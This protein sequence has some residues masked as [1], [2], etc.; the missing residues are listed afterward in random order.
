MLS[1]RDYQWLRVNGAS[2]FDAYIP[3]EAR[4]REDVCWF[5]SLSYVAAGAAWRRVQQWNR[6]SLWLQISNFKA[7]ARAW[8]DLERLNLWTLPGPE[9]EDDWDWY[10][11]ANGMLEVTFDPKRG[12][13]A[14]EDSF[15]NDHIW[16]VAAREDRWLTV[17]L[18]AF[19]DRADIWGR[20][21]EERV[22]VTPEGGIEERVEPDTEFWRQNATLYLVENVPFGTATVLVPRNARDPESYALA[23]AR[24]LVGGVGEPE[25]IDIDD[26]ARQVPGT[27]KPHHRD[28]SVILH[29]HGYY[30][31]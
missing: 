22:T 23:R 11:K 19:A 17:E 28:L 18:A 30:E 8:T 2:R 15:I 10:Y 6:P 13:A 12:P 16:R 25:H 4:T 24:E 3:L 9:L 14:R 26:F 7:P 29:F 5:L 27:D 20:L 21:P 31:D 1:F